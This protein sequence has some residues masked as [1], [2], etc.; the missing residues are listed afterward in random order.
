[1]AIKYTK[2]AE[3]MLVLRG[4]GQRLADSTVNNPDKTIPTRDGNKIYLK[5]LGKNYLMLVVAEERGD[6]IVVTVH[7]LDKKRAEKL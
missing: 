7:W 4:I 3:E 1:M 5:N 2:H 6:R